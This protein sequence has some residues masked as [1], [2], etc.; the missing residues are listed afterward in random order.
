MSA[1]TSVSCVPVSGRVL[2]TLMSCL[3]AVKLALG[4]TPVDLTPY[5]VTYAQP[6]SIFSAGDMYPEYRLVPV[7]WTAAMGYTGSGPTLENLQPPA[8]AV[9]YVLGALRMI[10]YLP[11]G[12]IGVG[13]LTDGGGPLTVLRRT[14]L[15][16]AGWPCTLDYGRGPP[17]YSGFPF[18]MAVLPT[19]VK[20]GSSVTRT[21][22]VFGTSANP[23]PTCQDSARREVTDQLSFGAPIRRTTISGHEYEASPMV[24]QRNGVPW[25]TYYFAYRIGIAGGESNWVE[26]NRSA[27]AADFPKFPSSAENFEL[28]TLPPPIIEGEVVEFVNAKVSPASVGGHYFYASSAEDKAALDASDDWIRTGRQFKSGGYV[29]VCRFLYKA[30]GSSSGTHFFTAKADECTQF[31]TMAG[32]TYEGTPFRASLPAAPVANVAAD[33]PTRCPPKTVP[34]YRFFNNP[35]AGSYLPNHRYLTNR[36]AGQVTGYAGPGKP[37]Q[38]WADEGIAL[39]V[40]G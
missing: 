2:L 37:A 21:M 33:D 36:A 26:S 19:K 5:Y 16:V 13:A 30:P 11:E 6:E 31:K 20:A 27:F 38:T 15:G 10:N 14:I 24:M 8:N 1:N 29:P 7:E 34:L 39:C 28:T 3:L 23:I 40:A 18:H 35:A 32:F 17:Y 25:M 4:Q 12:S 9:A 22:T